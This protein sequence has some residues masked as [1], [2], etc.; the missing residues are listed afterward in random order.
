[1]KLI[2][3]Q[4]R[5][6]ALT[7]SIEENQ[8]VLDHLTALMEEYEACVQLSIKHHNKKLKYYRKKHEEELAAEE[9]QKKLEE[10]AQTQQEEGGSG[11]NQ[12]NSPSPQF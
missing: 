12:N 6:L 5:V 4:Q 10:E 8:K 11:Q 7:R 3:F 9:E 1:M 2:H